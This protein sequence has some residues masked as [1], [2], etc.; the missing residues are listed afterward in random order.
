[1]ATVSEAVR[2]DTKKGAL[3]L[4]HAT[5]RLLLLRYSRSSAVG[6]FILDCLL[7]IADN[8]GAKRPPR[9]SFELGNRP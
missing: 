5:L 3:K 6:R 2:S 1:M 8:N 4:E 9:G 7:H